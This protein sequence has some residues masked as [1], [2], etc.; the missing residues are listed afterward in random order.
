MMKKTSTKGQHPDTHRPAV[1][2]S[3][4]FPAVV[5]ASMFMVSC[6]A[7]IPVV[8]MYARE[9]NRTKAKAEMPVPAE[10]VYKT[11]LE[12]A[13]EKDLKIL[14]EEDKKMYLEVTDGIQTASLKAEPAGTDKS[15]VTVTA[16]L[17]SKKG[18]EE[19]MRK[20]KEK[21]LTL[22]IVNRICDRLEVKCTIQKE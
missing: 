2:K 8:I 9:A 7:A 1:K 21:E 5:V 18:E 10:K 22:R 16:T 4:I 11:A 17:P 6:F 15:T 13:K 20:E 12:M 3:M 19:K 14:K